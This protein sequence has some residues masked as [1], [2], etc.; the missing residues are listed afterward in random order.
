ML[1]RKAKHLA[2]TAQ[3]RIRSLARFFATL[4]FAQNDILSYLPLNKRITII[5]ALKSVSLSN[6]QIV[7]SAN[8]G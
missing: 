1:S 8:A 3:N 6:Y 7:E 2:L 5:A 4:R